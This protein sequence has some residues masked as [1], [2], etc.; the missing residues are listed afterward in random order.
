VP[1]AGPPATAP[2]APVWGPGHG[3]PGYGP[4]AYGVPGYPP[5]GYPPVGYP[6][7]YG[8]P[9]PWPVVPR[10]P[11]RPGQVIASAVLAFV[12]AALVLI[13]SI[14]VW[15]FASLVTVATSEVPGSF[16]ASTAEGLATE[17]TVLSAVQLLSAVLLVTAGVMALNR[18]S[19]GTWVLLVVGHAVQ[20]VLSVYWLVRL[21]ILAG[22]VPGGDVDTVLITFTL[23][24]AAGPV[25]GLGLIVVGAGRRWF[26]P[27]RPAVAAPAT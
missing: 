6:P 15:L 23:F 5:A 9:A 16:D 19:R 26:E 10:G 3:Q 24:F 8:Y 1:Y 13:A 25:V 20:I 18:R 11:R 21:L 17:G 12:Q 22:D 14:Y 4:P 7:G 27:D 2:P